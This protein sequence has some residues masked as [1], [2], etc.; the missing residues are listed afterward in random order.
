M[1]ENL[2]EFARNNKTSMMCHSIESIIVSIFYIILVVNGTY[3]VPYVCI[4]LILALLPIILEFIFW[5][6]N[7]E[8]KLIQH[9]VG[10]G[11]SILYTFILFTTQNSLV[12]VLALPMILAISVYNNLRTSILIF[13]GLMVENIIVVFG[14]ALTGKFAY[15]NSTFGAIQII[16]TFMMG[17]YCYFVTKTTSQNNNQKIKELVESEDKI[18]TILAS[19][20]SQSE[21]IKNGIGDIHEQVEK[22]S[23]TSTQTK[24]AMDEVTI[25]INDTSNAV[26]KQLLQTQE[27]QQKVSTISDTAEWILKNINETLNVVKV[28]NSNVENLVNEVESSVNSGKNV[29]EKLTNL[30]YYMEEMNTI[31]ELISGITNQTGL[32]ALNANI[33]AARAGE[34]GKGFSVVATEI[35]AMA[36]Q[37]KDATA[38]ISDLISNVSSAI[39]QVVGVI[40]EMLVGIDKEK[41][42][43]SHTAESFENIEKNTYEISTNINNLTK[44]INELQ[45]SNNEISNSIETISAVSEEV[46]AHSVETLEAQANNSIMLEEIKKAAQELLNLTYKQN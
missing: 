40:E 1:K 46:S 42:F 22:L 39:E 6:K 7:N 9:F 13:I 10:I 18:K 8:S 16:L 26:Q 35:S 31:V 38:H 24:S 33:E 12:F 2:S 37:T 34:A 45:A 19:M 43:T 20:S 14:G 4:V 32:L 27:I 30:K 41:D 44:S 11:F 5:K 25:G 3:T 29:T 36:L 17:M 15:E 21:A 28:G 23:E